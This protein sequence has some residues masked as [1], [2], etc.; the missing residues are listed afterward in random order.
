MTVA[1][2]ITELQKMPPDL[3]VTRYC[4]EVVKEVE[5]RSFGRDEGSGGDLPDHYTKHVAL[6]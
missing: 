3:P 2:L 5:L 6:W 4:D 1:E